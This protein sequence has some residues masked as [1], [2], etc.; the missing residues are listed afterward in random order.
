MRRLLLV[1]LSLHGGLVAA[2]LLLSHAQP[3]AAEEPVRME[4]IFGANGAT[5][6]LPA[7]PAAPAT[8]SVATVDDDGPAAQPPAPVAPTVRQASADPGLHVDRPDPSLIPARN[9]PGNRAPDYP[10]GAWLRHEQ[11]TV[12]IRLSIAP[13]GTVTR[14]EKLASSGYPALDDAATGAL[15][16]WHFLP[17]HRDGQ[18]VASYRDQPVR[19]EIQ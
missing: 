12:L 16:H 7:S 4:V 5:P 6:A 9:D 3:P 11:G 8:V 2:M 1:S 19:F 10:A 14:L 17:A 15:S 18:P 13:D